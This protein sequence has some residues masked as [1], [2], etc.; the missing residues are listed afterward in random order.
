VRPLHKTCTAPNA[1]TPLRLEVAIKVLKR[2]VG[3]SPVM[4]DADQLEATR[5]RAVPRA[6][7]M[8]ETTSRHDP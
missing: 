6:V 1:D 8:S 7:S 2:S 3:A 4:F 5:I